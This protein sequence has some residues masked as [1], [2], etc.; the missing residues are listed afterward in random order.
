[1]RNGALTPIKYHK[2][3]FV[4]QSSGVKV[5]DIWLVSDG[6]KCDTNKVNTVNEQCINLL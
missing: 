3:S 1:M 5:P 4:F 2:R 6:T